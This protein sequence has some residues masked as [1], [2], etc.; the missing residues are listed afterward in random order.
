MP[1]AY[2][3]ALE[4]CELRREWDHHPDT[5]IDAQTVKVQALQEEFTQLKRSLEREEA[6]L[7][8]QLAD[9]EF[10]RRHEVGACKY[11]RFYS[12]DYPLE[13]RSSVLQLR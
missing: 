3:T 4:E 8:R 11:K 6:I 10:E 7:K 12:G 1:G 13:Q 5:A 9:Q 2:C